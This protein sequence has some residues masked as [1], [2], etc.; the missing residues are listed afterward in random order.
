M[1]IQ[2]RPE[3]GPE[4]LGE[5]QEA[6]LSA[7]GKWEA[8]TRRHPLQN[9]ATPPPFL[10]LSPQHHVLVVKQPCSSLECRQ[11]YLSDLAVYLS[12]LLP[13]TQT[14]PLPLTKPRRVH[15]PS[16]ESNPPST[17]KIQITRSQQFE[18]RLTTSN[19]YP[20]HPKNLPT[21]QILSLSRPNTIAAHPEPVN[22]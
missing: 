6:R 4:R 16:N 21:V 1:T 19:D 10:S 17:V 5:R 15:A 7:T 12:D 22:P 11:Y 13:L 2:A 8:P 14:R 20:L 3:K 9:D 18:T